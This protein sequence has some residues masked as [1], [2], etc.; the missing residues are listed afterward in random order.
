VENARNFYE[1]AG[2]KLALAEY[3]DPCGMF[4][5]GDLYIFVLDTNGIMLAHGINKR[6]VGENFM[7]VKDSEGKYF[8][9]E[10]VESAMMD[11]RG[12]VEYKWFNP[13]T[14]EWSPKTTYFEI[15]DDLII[16]AADYEVDR[17]GNSRNVE[18]CGTEVKPRFS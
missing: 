15:V 9:R 13:E 1:S 8:I 6:F 2:R 7:E 14:K 17:A 3:S 5:K 10:I 4:V 18:I 11:G 12:I 16:C